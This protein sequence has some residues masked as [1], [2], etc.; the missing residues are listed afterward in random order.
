VGISMV[1]ASAGNRAPRLLTT[2]APANVA[3]M[4]KYGNRHDHPDASTPPITNEMVMPAR[5]GQA[6]I[7][8]NAVALPSPW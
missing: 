3:A 8:A 2:I 7:A 4:R 1:G 5:P 6:L